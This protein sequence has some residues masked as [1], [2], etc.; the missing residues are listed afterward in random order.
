MDVLAGQDVDGLGALRAGRLGLLD[1]RAR[2][3]VAE[4]TS[5]ERR[6]QR[7]ALRAVGLLG[8]R[9]D[10]PA[11]GVARRRRARRE[12]SDVTGVV[13]AEIAAGTAS[14]HSGMWPISTGSACAAGAA[15][16]TAAAIAATA[17]RFTSTCPWS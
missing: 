16:R 1:D 11:A 14:V 7:D 4:A 5:G 12:R 3:G 2:I 10:L 6:R 17:K 9:E 15:V 8:A 13:S